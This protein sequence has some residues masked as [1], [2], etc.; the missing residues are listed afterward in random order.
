LSEGYIPAERTEITEETTQTHILY[1][2]SRGGFFLD[3]SRKN[4]KEASRKI[5]LLSPL[6]PACFDVLSGA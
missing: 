6:F 5:P 2:F 3:E 4:R 1:R